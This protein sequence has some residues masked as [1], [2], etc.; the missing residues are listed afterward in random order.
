MTIPDSVTSIGNYAFKNCNSL[1]SVTLTNNVVN[2]GYLAFNGC[3]YLTSINFN[4]TKDEW[5]KISSAAGSASDDGS[6]TV[7]CSDG[8]I[9]FKLR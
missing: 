6:V 3:A 1:K 2:I 4:G 9:K 7:K 5:L 8:D